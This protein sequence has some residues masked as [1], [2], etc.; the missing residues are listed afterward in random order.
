MTGLL[1][2]EPKEPAGSG[3]LDRFDRLFDGWM[4]ALPIRRVRVDEFHENGTLVVRAEM[5]GLD[6]EKD[7]EVTVQ[8]GVLRIRAERRE[9]EKTEEDGY[10]RHELRSGSFARTIALPNGTADADIAASY[11]DGILEV[12]VPAPAPAPPTK[13]PVSR[14]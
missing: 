11:K 9:E 13:V 3:V 5:P 1:K 4:K 14:G 8:E 7:I 12:R 10:V 2:R 6:P